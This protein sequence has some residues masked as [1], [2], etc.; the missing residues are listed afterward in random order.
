[1]ERCSVQKNHP[2]I[3]SLAL[4]WRSIIVNNINENFR[5]VFCKKAEIESSKEI[6]ICM[7]LP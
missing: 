6:M 7:H 2:N 5:S 3:N 1:M 4:T